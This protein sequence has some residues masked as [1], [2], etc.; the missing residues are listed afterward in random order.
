KVHRNW[1][2]VT[3][4][5]P[6]ADWYWEDTSEWTL[7]YP[8]LFGY[9]EWALSQAA[10]Y[11]EP[12]L[13]KI[14][15]C[16]EPSVAAVWFQRVSVMVVDVTM[17]LGVVAWCKGASMRRHSSAVPQGVA[18]ATCV[19]P[20][21]LL[22]SGLFL[23]DHVH[24]QYN[25]FLLGLLLLSMG[26]IRQG[27]VLSGGATFACL[28]MLKHLFLALAPLYFVYLLR[29]YCCGASAQQLSKGV[30]GSGD[31][32]RGGGSSVGEAS[33]TPRRGDRKNPQRAVPSVS[34]EQARA[35]SRE[36]A[37][38]VRL[39]WKR[40]ASLGSAVL[41]VFGS[42][43]GP[44]CVSDGWTKDA[45]LKQLGQ[46]GVRLFPFG[47]RVE[48]ESDE[49]ASIA[50]LV[51][52]Y[53]APNVWA[54]Y[55]FLDRA[56]LASLKLAGLVA[57][58]DGKGSTTAG[59]LVRTEIMAML[60]AVPTAVC[61]VLSV[62]ACWPAFVRAW[63]SPS[64]QVFAWGVV[65]CS[66]SAFLVGFHV[67]E[68]ALLV[69]AVV[70]ALLASHSRAGA[71]MYLRLSFL[72]AFSVFPLL[73]GPELRVLKVVLLIMHMMLATSLLEHRHAEN[74]KDEG[75]AP[76]H[77]RVSERILAGHSSERSPCSA[78]GEP[79]RKAGCSETELVGLTPGQRAGAGVGR[80]STG[81]KCAPAA[82]GLWTRWDKAYVAGAGVIFVLGEVVH[83]LV[84]REGTL[85]F[86]PLMGVSVF[87]A[88]GVM[89]CWG[90]SVSTFSTTV[91]G[92]E[93]LM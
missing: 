29:S 39:S 21:V 73:P 22:N 56:L 43:L 77:S 18:C 76:T 84:F 60:P 93:E 33:R 58:S 25:G 53:W 12:D 61:L 10:V 88:V 50:G 28:L 8:P 80:V 23:V 91:Q 30:G 68:K 79:A 16:Y 41:F 27:R 32:G 19:G 7:D 57:A 71:R 38:S 92:N 65:H 87:G 13:V 64:A 1:L 9:F 54:V 49:P 45:C 11:I 66:L 34:H 4:S 69:P 70:S 82:P 42:V 3:H 31:V 74:I 24:F 78:P 40:L 14:T 59:G 67:H 2:A 20:L 26:L 55:L 63:K 72:A 47:R 44:L 17:V 52:A 83:P 6:L 62:L 51:H 48:T 36:E 81:G 15:P 75:M 5:K 46:L 85:P 90:L 35:V 37:P 89:A 86:L